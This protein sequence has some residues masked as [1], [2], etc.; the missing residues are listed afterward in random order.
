[1]NTAENKI[2]ITE[3]IEPQFN[4]RDEELRLLAAATFDRCPDCG[5]VLFRDGGCPFC[6]SCGWSRC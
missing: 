1:M 4:T 6:P 3:S 2:R 5:G